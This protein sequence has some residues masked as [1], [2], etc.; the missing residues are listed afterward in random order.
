MLRLISSVSTDIVVHA[1]GRNKHHNHSMC[2]VYSD[3]D[4]LEFASGQRG[5]IRA[6]GEPDSVSR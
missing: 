6:Q 4:R 1:K 3:T 2:H 5:D